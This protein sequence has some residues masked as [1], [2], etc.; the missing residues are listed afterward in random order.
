MAQ[1]DK[2]TMRILIA[3]IPETR[4]RLL[5]LFSDC[6][7]T[8]AATMYE[9]EEVLLEPVDAVLIAVR[10]D[11]SRMFDLLRHMKS[12]SS[13]ARLPVICYRTESGPVTATPLALQAVQL[14]ARS[15]GAHDFIDLVTAHS[16]KRLRDTVLAAIAAARQVSSNPPS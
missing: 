5:R 4:D 13:L 1:R 6:D 15:L 3:G 11:E 12:D 14:A 9:A 10:F 16:D 2:L 7:V 8:F